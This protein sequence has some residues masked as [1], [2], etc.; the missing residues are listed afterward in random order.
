MSGRRLAL[1]AALFVPYAAVLAMISS[2]L[3]VMLLAG[4]VEGVR[5]WSSS[6]SSNLTWSYWT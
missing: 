2:L 3:W 5:E 1:L 4:P 6:V